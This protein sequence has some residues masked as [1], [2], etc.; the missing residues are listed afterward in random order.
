MKV[1]EQLKLWRSEFGKKYTDRNLF[2]PYL[3]LPAFKEMLQGLE[4]S[5]ILEIGC[6]RAIN[7]ETLSLLSPDWN[8]TGIEPND[9]ARK[10]APD[11]NPLINILPGSAFELP[12][13]DAAFDLVFTAS[14]L[15]HISLDDLPIA[16]NEI[17]RSTRTYILAI[18][19][20]AEQETEIYYQGHTNA[21]WKR[22][23]KS[24]YENLFPDLKLL[25]SGFEPRS[26]D[27]FDDATWW[28]WQKAS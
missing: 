18:E 12:V 28:L 26:E 17:Y 25:R 23:F 2:D 1:T 27:R 15:I 6:N 20:F 16:M 4:M 21:L 13:D 14:V 19:Y 22:D 5:E 10:V 24:L 9:Y 11:D 3:R 8:L 7:L